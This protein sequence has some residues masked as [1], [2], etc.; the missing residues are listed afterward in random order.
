MTVVPSSGSLPLLWKASGPVQDTVTYWPAVDPLTGDVWVASSL[1]SRLWVFRPDGTF[2]KEWGTPGSGPGQLKLKTN[3][4]NPDPVGAIAFAPDGTLYVADNGN[5]RI[6][7]FDPHGS[8]V[9]SWGSFGTDDGQ[10]VSPKGIATDG[11]SVDVADDTTGLMKVFDT[12]GRFE[13]S[14]GFP[15]VLFSLTPDGNLVAAD[16]H[17]SGGAISTT[18]DLIDNAGKTVASYPF[19]DPPYFGSVPANIQWGPGQAVEDGSGRIFVALSSD[20]GPVGLLELD[21]DGTV[22]RE[23]SSGG[24]TMALAP[25]GSAIYMAWAGGGG[26]PRW[27]YLTKYAIPKG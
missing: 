13:R 7:V 2:V 1:E 21:H 3:D 18:I 4:P 6:D 9:R 24:G 14:F 11:T 27:P 12:S 20:A 22:V 17:D 26:G 10:F 19:F 16:Y 25:D 15:F 5:Y 8:F 23:W